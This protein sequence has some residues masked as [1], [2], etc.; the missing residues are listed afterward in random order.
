ME[1]SAKQFY[2]IRV[3]SGNLNNVILV[4]QVTKLTSGFLGAQ[5]ELD[6]EGLERGA[7]CRCVEFDLAAD[8]AREGIERARARLLEARTTPRW[9]KLLKRRSGSGSCGSRLLM[10]GLKSSACTGSWSP[11]QACI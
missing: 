4:A 10:R 2:D 11:H 3:A 1:G 8:Q 7:R 9:T 6:S 5:P